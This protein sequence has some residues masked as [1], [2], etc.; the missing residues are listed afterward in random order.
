MVALRALIF[1][2]LNFL[3]VLMVYQERASISCL[4][5]TKEDLVTIG[6]KIFNDI[7]VG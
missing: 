4:N 1:W 5:K 3:F 6:N 7:T 2:L